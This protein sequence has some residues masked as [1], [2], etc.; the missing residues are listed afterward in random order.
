MFWGMGN[1]TNHA[2][3]SKYAVAEDTTRIITAR[4]VSDG[5]ASKYVT[6]TD[7]NLALENLLRCTIRGWYNKD[8]KN[9]SPNDAQHCG[10]ED[11]QQNMLIASGR[12]GTGNLCTWLYEDHGADREYLNAPLLHVNPKGYVDSYRFPKYAYFL[13]QATYGEKPMVF[14]QPHFWR[15]Q[16]NGQLKDINV[17][18]NCDTVELFVN[19][20]SQ[21]LQFPD[22]GN[23]H[24]VTFRNIAVTP[25]TLSAIGRI[26]GQKV[27]G[28]VKMAGQSSKIVVTAS[29]KKIGATMSSVVI[30]KADITDSTGSHIY[31]ATNTVRWSIL[32]PATLAGPQVYESDIAKHHSMEGTMYI[33]MPVAN[34]IRSTGK[35]G[36]IIVT[37]SSPGLASGSC[38][39]TAEEVLPDNSVILE[40][41]PA[42]EGRAAVARNPVSASPPPEV[43][44]EIRDNADEII[45]AP[46]DKGRYLSFVSAYVLMANPGLDTSSIEFMA[47]ADMFADHLVSNSG[48][49]IADD[50]NF[51]ANNYNTCRE[52]ARYVGNTSLP[53]AFRSAVRRDYARRIIKEGMSI[54][55]PAE[56][57]MLKSIPSEGNIVYVQDKDALSAGRNGVLT[58]ETDLAAIV[59]LVHP[60]FKDW[61]AGSKAKVLEQVAGFN[62]FIITTLKGEV[63][64]DRKINKAFYRIVKGEPVWIPAI[65]YLER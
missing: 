7:N 28:S 48:R 49:L 61:P 63:V 27:T 39:I 51:F 44:K 60:E 18:S 65:S 29:H 45:L 36:T 25:G 31:G 21:G 56:E 33:D 1:E 32:G 37:V 15:K 22:A 50:Y 34:V 20:V 4:R 35:P 57:A 3:D 30:I 52:L 23:F 6:H 12:F 26:N 43:K 42:P 53:A 47:L 38:R 17:S 16:Y 64:N 9:L 46:S 59:A 19:G 14:I 11:H 2:V 13:W 55:L 24:N 41:V 8:V 58:S 10:T 62:P 5:S 40:P 54:N